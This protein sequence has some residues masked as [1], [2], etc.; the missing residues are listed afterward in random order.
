MIPLLTPIL[1]TLLLAQT[2]ADRTVSGEVVDDKGKPVAAAELVLYSPPTVYGKGVS[3]EVRAKSD[4]QDKFRLIVPPLERIVVNGV[5]LFRLIDQH[6]AEAERIWSQTKGMSRGVPMDP[7][8]CWKMAGVD[9]TR[10]RRGIEGFA[11]IQYAPEEY[12]FLALGSKAR[13]ESAASPGLSDRSLH[14]ARPHHAKG[15]PGKISAC[16]RNTGADRRANRSGPGAGNGIL[17]PPRCG[18]ARLPVG[19]PRT[20]RRVFAVEVIVEITRLA[21]YDREVAAVLHWNP[22]CSSPERRQRR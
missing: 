14:R 20:A 11:R 7:T 2:S 4:A 16:C 21:W 1:A 5:H 17:R 13:D 22:A 9:P 3:V 12:L 18:S 10:A 15:T 6:S 8:L 19:N